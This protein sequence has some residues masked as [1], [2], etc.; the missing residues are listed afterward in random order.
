M[1]FLP[2]QGRPMA[3]CNKGWQVRCVC[4][5]MIMI[6]LDIQLPHPAVC[7]NCSSPSVARTGSAC[8]LP[9]R[10]GKGWQI[11]ADRTFLCARVPDHDA[12]TDYLWYPVCNV[13]DLLTCCNDNAIAFN[14]YKLLYVFQNL[15]KKKKLMYSSSARLGVQLYTAVPAGYAPSSCSIPTDYGPLP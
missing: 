2:G 8:L 11:G 12:G 9:V 4:L 3:K 5:F 1:S 14:C 6:M 15:L 7:C 13:L 10:V